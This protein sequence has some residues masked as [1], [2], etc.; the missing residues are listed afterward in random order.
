MS[1]RRRVLL[2]A[3]PLALVFALWAGP[4]LSP[5]DGETRRID[6]PETV[7]RPEAPAPQVVPEPE[8][9]APPDPGPD[10]DR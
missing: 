6:L 3:L 7:T 8:C 4:G 10:G 5:D 9:E 1:P 2:I